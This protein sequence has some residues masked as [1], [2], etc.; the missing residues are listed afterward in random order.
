MGAW[1]FVIPIPPWTPAAR[2]AWAPSPV[3]PELVVDGGE[4]VEHQGP[5]RGMDAEGVAVERHGDWF[6]ERDPLRDAVPG[7]LPGGSSVLA[8][9]FR[10]FPVEP[11]AAVFQRQRECPSGTRWPWGRCRL[12][13]AGRSAGWIKS[14]PSGF[15][16]PGHR[17]GC[18]PTARENR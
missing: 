11:A 9:A 1:R 12:P 4:R 14:R 10:G 6:V 18:R 16:L 15:S 3:R 7:S 17:V 2:S 8:K 5:A 13:A